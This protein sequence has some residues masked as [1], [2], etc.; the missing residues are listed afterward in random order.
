MEKGANSYRFNTLVYI[1]DKYRDA[2]PQKVNL[3]WQT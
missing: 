1:N 3:T 2:S